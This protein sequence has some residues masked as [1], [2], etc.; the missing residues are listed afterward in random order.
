MPESSAPRR[1][2]AATPR[3]ERIQ[4]PPVLT[5]AHVWFTSPAR[6]H[7]DRAQGKELPLH[8]IQLI[9]EYLDDVGD[10]AR[11]TRTSRLFYYMT[12][13]RLYEQVTLRSYADIRYVNGRPEGYGYGSPFAMGLNTLVSRNFTEYVQSFRVIGE[14]REH[15]VDDY[16]KG[17][18]PDNSMILQVALRAALDRMKNLQAFAYVQMPSFGCC[19]AQ[20]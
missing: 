18:V 19:L 7:S 3:T 13:P 12:L 20:C 16:S 10:L 5:P 2:A 11:I 8:L 6:S 4:G 1:S 17:R 15:D 9:L 14:W